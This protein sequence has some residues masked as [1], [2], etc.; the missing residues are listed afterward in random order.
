MQFHD[1]ASEWY[2]GY[3]ISHEPPD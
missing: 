2:D 3:L 1:S